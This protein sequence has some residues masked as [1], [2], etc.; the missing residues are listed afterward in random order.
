MGELKFTRSHEWVKIEGDYALIGIADYA[1]R[2]L[3]DVVFVELPQVGDELKQLSQ[4]GIIE[5]TKAAGELYAP[6]SGEVIEIND[7]L[8]N[9]PQWVNESPLEKGWMLKIK[10]ADSAELDNLLDEDAHRKLVEKET[11]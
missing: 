1:Q 4:F 8:L 9:N 3:G 5:S 2:Q 10:I 7:S 11:S 6:L